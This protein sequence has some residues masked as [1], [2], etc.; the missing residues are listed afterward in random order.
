MVRLK[1]A[2]RILFD[3]KFRWLLTETIRY[4]NRT[5]LKIRGDEASNVIL[6]ME[7]YGDILGI[8]K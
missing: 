1:F 6:F 8:Y 7:H 5:G 3:R 4:A 2:W